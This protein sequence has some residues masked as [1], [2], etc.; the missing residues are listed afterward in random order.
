MFT[1]LAHVI[2]LSK[3][4]INTDL[5]AIIFLFVRHGTNGVGHLLRQTG[6]CLF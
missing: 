1:F 6:F 4:W 5:I 3:R 2:Y